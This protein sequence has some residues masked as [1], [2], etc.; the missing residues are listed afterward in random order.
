M[1]SPGSTV[2]RRQSFRSWWTC[3]GTITS[4]IFTWGRTRQQV[5]VQISKQR[6]EGRRDQ[7]LVTGV[8][9]SRDDRHPTHPLI[10]PIR[11]L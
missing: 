7:S 4:T 9:P 10:I 6:G 11:L 3:D 2:N 5:I 1:M 8:E